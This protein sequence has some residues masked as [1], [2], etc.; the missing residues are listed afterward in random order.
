MKEG[1]ARWA[2]EAIS[3]M[4]GVAMYAGCA[5]V[6]RT[7]NLYSADAWNMMKKGKGPPLTPSTRFVIEDDEGHYAL[8]CA[9]VPAV[10]GMIEMIYEKQEE[11]HE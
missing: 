2:E 1:I 9:D 4:A 10:I 7:V 5:H 8:E 3:D 6:S 11:A